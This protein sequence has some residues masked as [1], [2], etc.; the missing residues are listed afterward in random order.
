MLLLLHIHHASIFESPLDNVGV[1]AGALDPFR[2][3]QGGPEVGKVLQL[4]VMPDVGE[5][6]LDDGTFEDRRGGGNC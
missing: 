3:F 1:G 5:G 6:S 4:D 2:L